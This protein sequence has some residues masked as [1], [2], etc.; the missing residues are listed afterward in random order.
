MIRQWYST[1]NLPS[2]GTKVYYFSKNLGIFRGK[3]YYDT[4]TMGNPHKFTN[5]YGIVD[6]DDVSHWMPY[7]RE[8]KN[9]I[10][11][12]PDYQTA[13]TVNL[14]KNQQ[15]FTFTYSLTDD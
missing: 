8:E 1:N 11:L 7:I 6:A 3:Y 4:E 2:P 14:D 10:P 5:N 12:P 15:T 13:D 9:K